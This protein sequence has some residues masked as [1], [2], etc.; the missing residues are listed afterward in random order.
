MVCIEIFPGILDR[1]KGIA[2]VRII[3]HGLDRSLFSALIKLKCELVFLQ[4]AAF[5]RLGSVKCD[6][7]RCLVSV[8]HRDL[9]G[10][11]DFD[12]SFGSR[13]RTFGVAVGEFCLCNGVGRACGQACDLIDLAGCQCD[14]DFAVGH[15]CVIRLLAVKRCR[16]TA[17]KC[18]ACRCSQCDLKCE[19]LIRG[20]CARDS[21]FDLDRA[22]S[23]VCQNT[24]KSLKFIEGSECQLSALGFAG[25]RFQNFASAFAVEI[26]V[27]RSVIPLCTMRRADC[28]SDRIDRLVALRCLGLCKHIFAIVKPCAREDAAGPAQTDFLRCAV[29]QLLLKFERC[30]FQCLA[31]LVDLVYVELV[32]EG[33]DIVPRRILEISCISRVIA[34]TQTRCVDVSCVSEF[35]V[36]IQLR[37]EVD[38]DRGTVEQFTDWHTLRAVITSP[39]C[40][41]S[42][43]L[44]AARRLEDTVPRDILRAAVILGQDDFR[45]AFKGECILHL[46]FEYDGVTSVSAD[47]IGQRCSQLVRD[48]V[49][50]IVIGAVLPAAGISCRI[51]GVPDLLLKGRSTGLIVGKLSCRNLCCLSCSNNDLEIIVGDQL[52]SRRVAARFLTYGISSGQK[53]LDLCLTG[54]T[55]CDRDGLR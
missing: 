27:R 19:F 39:S 49:A 5:E 20:S 7:A 13:M 6:F 10:L 47:I 23:L 2:S 26:Q 50:D 4:I 14:C 31:I 1:L 44:P 29:C 35:G 17:V 24:F 16:I 38:V 36:L 32:S 21:L 40:A 37:R 15:C 8:V 48:L 12:R 3:G 43:S 33:N 51:I 30:S 41:D 25:E 45:D 55:V 18:C 9:R 28:E 46:I 52:H 54:Y 34:V 11:A 22:N 53:T 42:E